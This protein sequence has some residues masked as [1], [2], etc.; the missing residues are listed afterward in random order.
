MNDRTYSKQHKT[1]FSLS[2]TLNDMCFCTFL[3]IQT[4]QR[5]RR[6]LFSQPLTYLLMNQHIFV[7]RFSILTSRYPYYQDFFIPNASKTSKLARFFVQHPSHTSCYLNDHRLFSAN[8]SRHQ[9]PDSLAL[10]NYIVF[11][12]T[13]QYRSLV[14]FL[15]R[16]ATLTKTQTKYI[17]GVTITT[18]ICVSLTLANNSQLA[19]KPQG[20]QLMLLLITR[21]QSSHQP[22]HIYIIAFAAIQ[23]AW[24]SIMLPQQPMFFFFLN[25]NPSQHRKLACV[26]LQSLVTEFYTI[27]FSVSHTA[28]AAAKKKTK[29][30]YI[31]AIATTVCLALKQASISGWLTSSQETNLCLSPDLSKLYSRV[32]F[33]FIVSSAAKKLSKDNVTITTKIG[34]VLTLAS[35]AGNQLV[36]VSRFRS[37]H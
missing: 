5:H 29:T 12:A 28:A 13:V 18:R 11:V 37:L 32:L 2:V 24:Q 19:N 1:F 36:F 21:F 3:H 25:T 20:N 10:A 26:C 33:Y 14:A 23:F 17:V 34:L 6:W 7:T 15:A 8:V 4:A 35:I 30:K 9:L 31:V 27:L 16:R 22:H